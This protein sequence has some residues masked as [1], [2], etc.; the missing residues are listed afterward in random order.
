MCIIDAFSR[1][2]LE[3][4]TSF[5]FYSLFCPVTLKN[6]PD[7]FP[8]TILLVHCVKN[9]VDGRTCIHSAHRSQDTRIYRKMQRR[10]KSFLAS[11]T[12][13]RHTTF[14]LTQF[15]LSQ[16]G[17]SRAKPHGAVKK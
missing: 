8:A 11:L 14:H 12:Q 6:L 7:D 17:R 10:R 15:F 2:G 5:N 4:S 1:S 9:A 3:E 16:S 13:L